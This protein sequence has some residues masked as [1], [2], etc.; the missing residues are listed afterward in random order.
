YGNVGSWSARFLAD[1]GARVVAVSDV[2]GGIHSGDGLDLEAVNEAVADAGSVVGARGVER[3]SNEEL[4]TL[5]VD[6]LVPAALGHV[7]HGGNARDVRARL[8]VEG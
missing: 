2:E 5:D 6:V 8:I 4:L 3:I 1:I 7:I